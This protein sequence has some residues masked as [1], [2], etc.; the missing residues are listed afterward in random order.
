MLPLK[1][2]H[3]ATRNAQHTTRP[4]SHHQCLKLGGGFWELF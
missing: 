2:F 4:Q 1:L 3:L